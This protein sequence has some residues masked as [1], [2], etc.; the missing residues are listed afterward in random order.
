MNT[1]EI[2]K[3]KLIINGDWKENKRELVGKA[4][5][6]EHLYCRNK[7]KRYGRRFT[8]AGSFL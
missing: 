8:E 4:P 6:D 5:L 3:I 1:N 7:D 2:A